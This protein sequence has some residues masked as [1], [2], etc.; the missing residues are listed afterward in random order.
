M[1]LSLESAVT[2][3][4]DAPGRIAGHSLDEW[5]AAY[6]K[7][8]SYFNALR[9]RNKLLLGQVVSRVLDRA[10][11]RAADEPQ[12]PPMEL[13]GEEM[14]SVVSEWFTAVLDIPAATTNELLSVRGRLALL[15][16]DMPGKWQEQFLRPGPWPE[17]FVRAMRETYLRAGP[18]FQSSRM[19]PRPI[20][21]GPITA[22]TKLANF[23][24]FRVV[25]LWLAFAAL[26]V[27]L[28]QV[29]H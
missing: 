14:D 25:L 2:L 9:V 3:P 23:P 19:S 1:V 26:L 8:E 13:A 20:D 10:I 5:N 12:R 22:L 15:L 27:V 24:Y 21:L 4:L 6:T 18:D 29:T 28:F 17:E 16:A 7:V 11:R